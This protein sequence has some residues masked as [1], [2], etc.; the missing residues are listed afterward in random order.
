M[1]AFKG[2]LSDRGISLVKCFLQG[3]SFGCHSQD[4]SAIGIELAIFQ[5]GTGMEYLCP[6]DLSVFVQIPGRRPGLPG[7]GNCDR[8]VSTIPRG[9]C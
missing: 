8:I 4:T 6:F 1:S 7:P 2:N 3:L 5:F 9:R